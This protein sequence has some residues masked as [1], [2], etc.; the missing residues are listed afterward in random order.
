MYTAVILSQITVSREYIYGIYKLPFLPKA[1]IIYKVNKHGSEC[2][3]N[4]ARSTTLWLVDNFHVL[5]FD[6]WRVC[7]YKFS[8]FWL[9]GSLY[10]QVL[11]ALIGW[12]LVRTTLWLVESLYILR[13]DWWKTCTL[14]ALIGGELARTTL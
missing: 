9:V 12:E 6:W 7:A 2:S 11:Y 5:R 4:V 1:N 10:V 14:Y 13:F 3:K 8:T